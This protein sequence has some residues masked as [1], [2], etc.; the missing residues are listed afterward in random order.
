MDISS[1][2]SWCFILL[3]TQPSKDFCRRYMRSTECPSSFQSR[4]GYRP[5]FHQVFFWVPHHDGSRWGTAV[6][7]TVLLSLQQNCGRRNGCICHK[8]LWVRGHSRSSMHISLATIVTIAL[9]CTVF[10]IFDVEEDHDLEIH[11]NYPANLWTICR[12]ISEICRHRLSF[13]YW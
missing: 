9:S 13:C 5:E 7:V 1:Q 3:F 2:A 8:T 10:E 6:F 12:P 4:R 11:V